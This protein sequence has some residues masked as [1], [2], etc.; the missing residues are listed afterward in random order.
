[1]GKRTVTSANSRCVTRQR[2][3]APERDDDDLAKADGGSRRG[4][5]LS[6]VFARSDEPLQ[7]LMQRQRI[8]RRHRLRVVV[9]VGKDTAAAL[10][11]LGEHMRPPVELAT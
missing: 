8:S 2:R 4:F 7:H 5:T 10:H 6:S 3:R 1:M 9:E 11:L